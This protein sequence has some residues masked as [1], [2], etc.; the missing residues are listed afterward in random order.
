MITSV[1]R[2]VQKHLGKVLPISYCHLFGG[3]ILPENLR[4]KLPLSFDAA[5]KL[6]EL[7]IKRAKVFWICPNE[8][9]MW[10][11]GTKACSKCNSALST[12]RVFYYFPLEDR[13]RE[14]FSNKVYKHFLSRSMFVPEVFLPSSPPDAQEVQ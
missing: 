5:V 1:F 4:L 13:I 14:F 9:E 2:A 10:P 3:P 12:K 7:N 6:L 11:A 8:C